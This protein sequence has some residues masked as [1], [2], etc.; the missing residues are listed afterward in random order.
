MNVSL[1]Q[2][3][4]AMNAT[5]RWQEVI[6]ENLAASS[7]PGA[8]RQDVTFSAVEAGLAS[9]NVGMGGHRYGMPAANSYINFTEG[10]MNPT[11]VNTDFAMEGPAFFQVELPN[12]NKGYTR[13]GTFQ[14]SPAG[15]LVTQQGYPVLTEN[16]NPIQLDPNNSAPIMVSAT[17]NISL[18]EDLL[19]KLEE[20]ARGNYHWR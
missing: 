3:A 14:L 11:G 13:N 2:A 15:Q 18:P 7:A 1:Y 12:G 20:I 16:G 10:Q 8:R 5:S 4:A 6:S 19:P 17:G 9:G